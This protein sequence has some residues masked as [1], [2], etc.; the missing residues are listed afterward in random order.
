VYFDA[1]VTATQQSGLTLRA[2]AGARLTQWLG[3]YGYAQTNTQ[4]GAEAGAGIRVTW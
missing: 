3:T 2:E 1:L 4:R